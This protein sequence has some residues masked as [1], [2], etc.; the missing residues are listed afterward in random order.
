[1]T[2]TK[3]AENRLRRRAAQ[4]GLELKKSRRRD[5]QSPDYDRY[6]LVDT[7]TGRAVGGEQP[8]G[9]IYHLT[10]EEVEETLGARR[11]DRAGVG[12]RRALA[13]ARL[14]VRVERVPPGG[15]PPAAAFARAWDEWCIERGFAAEHGAKR[16]WCPSLGRHLNDAEY[17]VYHEDH[18]I[19]AVMASELEG[20]D[21]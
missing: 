21:G 14:A 6:A 15:D 18:L 8:V 16:A 11:R 13:D 17:L 9:G 7:R 1:M 20:L 12:D 3:S 4:V 19:A 5:P 2:L 10:V